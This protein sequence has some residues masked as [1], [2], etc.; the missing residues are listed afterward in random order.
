MAPLPEPR[1]QT[2]D[3]IY[4]AYQEVNESFRGRFLGTS[5]LGNPCDRALW[6][7]FRWASPI[8]KFD[9]RMLRL[10]ET[11]RREERRVMDDLRLAC[12]T[13]LDRDPKTH[14]QWTG[15]ACGGH[16]VGKAD[17]VGIGFPEAEKTWH[18]IEAKTCSA[19]NYTPL[20]KHGVFKSSPGHHIQCQVLMLLLDLNRTLYLAHNKDTDALYSERVK[21]DKPFAQAQVARAQRV[22]DAVE[23]PFGVSKDP[24][25]HEC[26]FCDHAPICHG[27]Q[28]PERNCRTCMYSTPIDGGK[29]S[30]D[31]NKTWPCN[32]H[33]YIPPLVPGEQVD[34]GD[35]WVE[36][37]LRTTEV[38]R[39]GEC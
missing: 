12:F 18:V 38:W 7:E 23:P 16:L 8:K 35:G 6:Y 14:R 29:W 26:R 36:Y 27:G 25:W 17:A 13:V 30:C 22:I 4:R 2:V 15:T 11:G 33:L 9:G 21:L 39:D 3:A 31:L 1:Q 37:L 28:L 24:A 34:A 20:V 32:H 5:L 10:F 19:K